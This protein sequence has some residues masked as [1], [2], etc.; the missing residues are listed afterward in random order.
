MHVA[1]V[2]LRLHFNQYVEVR[3]GFLTGMRNEK[4]RQHMVNSAW[5]VST[6]LKHLILS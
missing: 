1:A 6:D 5:G 3:G 4:L 2:V